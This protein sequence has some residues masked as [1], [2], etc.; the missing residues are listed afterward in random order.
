MSA[1]IHGLGSVDGEGEF[2]YR[3]NLEDQGEP[4]TNDRYW[5][6]IPAALYDSGDQQLDG[7]NVQIRG[8][9]TS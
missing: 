2:Q 3:I 1:E 9:V 4:G 8:T 5:I 7:G 6:I